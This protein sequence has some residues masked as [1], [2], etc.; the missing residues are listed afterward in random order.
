MGK[1]SIKKKY[2]N[3][4]H[5]H[6]HKKTLLQF[7]LEPNKKMLRLWL[8]VCLCRRISMYYALYPRANISKEDA[9]KKGNC[10]EGKV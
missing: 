9:E 2:P 10:K 5:T 3:Y 8:A 7:S 1:G 4:L 6:L